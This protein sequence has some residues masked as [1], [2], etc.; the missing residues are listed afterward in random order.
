MK[1]RSEEPNRRRYS[2]DANS[3]A[4]TASTVAPARSWL[5]K[6]RR[7]A[8]SASRCRMVRYRSSTTSPRASSERRMAL[9]TAARDAPPLSRLTQPPAS[10]GLARLPT[11]R[12]KRRYRLCTKA[13]LP[14]RLLAVTT[15]GRAASSLSSKT[16]VSGLATLNRLFWAWTVLALGPAATTAPAD[17]VAVAVKTRKLL[18]PA[19]P[20]VPPPRSMPAT[21]APDEEIDTPRAP[22]RKLLPST[23]TLKV[24]ELPAKSSRPVPPGATRKTLRATTALVV[25]PATPPPIS[26]A[27]EVDPGRSKVLSRMLRLWAP[28]NT[29]TACV[30]ESGSRKVLFWMVRPV[31]PCPTT[32][33][34]IAE[35]PSLPTNTLWTTRSATVLAPAYSTSGVAVC[36][37]TVLLVITFWA[38]AAVLT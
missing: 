2:S 7:P 23:R 14:V 24:P 22:A 21:D 4:C 34:A 31:T 17:A 18:P 6:A 5:T 12:R 33:R 28:K 11:R 20:W 30:A 15:L 25:R 8:A 10:L 32:N 19:L 37:N 27:P 13:A 3:C 29:L 9:A 35:P 38:A 16:T 1:V 36:V 26:T